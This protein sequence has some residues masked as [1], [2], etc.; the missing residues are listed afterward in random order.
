MAETKLCVCSCSSEEPPLSSA[1]FSS[2]LPPKGQVSSR[3]D[4]V[5]GVQL[6]LYSH[7]S[8]EVHVHVHALCMWAP[9]MYPS[10]PLMNM[11]H[12]HIHGHVHV[13]YVICVMYMHLP[14]LYECICLVSIT[15]YSC[16]LCNVSCTCT[17]TVCNM[18]HVQI[19]CGL[20]FSFLSSCNL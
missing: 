8:I 14:C 13:P 18:C 17:C 10:V 9:W 4:P 19:V 7:G 2:P 11:C 16:T 12:V 20:S 3:G 15:D 1:F 6:L 5:S